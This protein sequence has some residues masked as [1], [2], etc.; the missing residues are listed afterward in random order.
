V[1]I[2]KTLFVFMFALFIRLTY[3]WFFIDL[4]SLVLEDQMMYIQL[5]KILANTGYFLQDTGNG[6]IPVTERLPGY[7]A[8]LSLIYTVFGQENIAVVLV[9]IVID[10]LTCVVIALIAEIVVPSGFIIAGIVAALNLN[11][12]VWN[13]LDRYLIFIFIFT[14]YFIGVLLY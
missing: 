1:T 3:A 2:K 10:S 14:F 4:D 5:G 8:L 6:F 11:M 12:V 9:Q 7:P 13:D